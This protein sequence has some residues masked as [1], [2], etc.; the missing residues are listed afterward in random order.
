MCSC[1]VIDLKFPSD[2]YIRP[3]G[4]RVVQIQ[5][6]ILVQN[7][8]ELVDGWGGGGARRLCLI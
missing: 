8:W 1:S 2:V 5:C 6:C 3:V 7:F 4:L